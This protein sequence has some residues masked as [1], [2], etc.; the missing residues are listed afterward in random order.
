MTS[1]PPTRQAVR[2]AAVAQS[3]LY[4]DDPVSSVLNTK[5]WLKH[6]SSRVDERANPQTVQ[7]WAAPR[8]ASNN[9]T[10]LI[11]GLFR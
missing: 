6:D 2:Y 8:L 5:K 1:P 9:G 11:E 3:N 4:P 10:A 7:M